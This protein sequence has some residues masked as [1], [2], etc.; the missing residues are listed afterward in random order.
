MA[1]QENYTQFSSAGVVYRWMIRAKSKD[2]SL[3]EVRLLTESELW[4]FIKRL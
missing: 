2:G 3:K 4:R 1:Y